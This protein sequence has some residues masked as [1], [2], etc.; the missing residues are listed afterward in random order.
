[1]II[2]ALIC[3]IT[4]PTSVIAIGGAYFYFSYDD[5]KL[6]DSVIMKVE[7]RK[8][9]NRHV[10]YYIVN[11]PAYKDITVLPEVMPKKNS[12]DKIQILLNDDGQGTYVQ[13]RNTKAIEY[14]PKIKQDSIVFFICW[15]L[16]L[17]T[18]SC[19]GLHFFYIYN[20]KQNTDKNNS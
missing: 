17:F 6:T 10:T 15:L 12:G 7:D 14:Y 1:M 18:P 11:T 4:L 19:F 3:I 16:F 5:Y 8:F 2:F 20:K 13:H 9:K